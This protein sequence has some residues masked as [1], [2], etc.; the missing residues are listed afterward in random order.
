MDERVV[1]G[2]MVQLVL[3][4]EVMQIARQRY[5]DAVTVLA[6][7]HGSPQQTR[8]NIPH[9]L[10]GIQS[11]LTTAALVSKVLWNPTSYRDD[12]ER[13][14][15]AVM[16]RKEVRKLL[17]IRGKRWQLLE[18]RS[19]RNVLEH[20]DSEWESMLLDHPPASP[21]EVET[22]IKQGVEFSL[23]ETGDTKP[24]D[25][26]RFTSFGVSVPLTELADLAVDAGQR[27]RGYLEAHDLMF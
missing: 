3:Q 10:L 15:L 9:M 19:A 24:E 6:Q 27:A 17:R 20:F 25:N 11:I 21:E 2:F 5:T 22:Q 23:D 1:V 4:G 26:H 13:H 14:A 16:H 8:A 12:P 18:R 7:G